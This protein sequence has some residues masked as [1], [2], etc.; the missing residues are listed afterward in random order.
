MLSNI[1]YFTLLFLNG[2]LV[3]TKNKTI[4]IKRFQLID[5]VL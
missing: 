2:K 3:K 4:H 5:Y 1:L